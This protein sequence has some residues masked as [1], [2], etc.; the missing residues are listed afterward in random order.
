MAVFDLAH[1]VHTKDQSN[2]EGVKDILQISMHSMLCMS[3]MS[4]MVFV[5]FMQHCIQSTVTHFFTIKKLKKMAAIS[6]ISII[7]KNFKLLTSQSLGL[8]FSEC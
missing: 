3:K 2:V 1:C 6:L 8:Q 4:K 5:A 7:W